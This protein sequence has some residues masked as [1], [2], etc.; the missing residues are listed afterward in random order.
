MSSWNDEQR[1]GTMRIGVREEVA[2]PDA[3]NSIE[4]SL[5]WTSSSR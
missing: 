5:R 4:C 1:I 3:W 2:E